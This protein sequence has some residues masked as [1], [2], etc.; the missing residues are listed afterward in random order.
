MYVNELGRDRFA[1][2]EGGGQLGQFAPGPGLSG[3]RSPLSISGMPLRF[4]QQL[5][6]G[7]G[8][9]L[10]LGLRRAWSEFFKRDP[11]LQVCFFYTHRP[12]EGT[13]FWG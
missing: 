10:V 6:H 13:W 2:K 5:S 1:A 11:S 7:S 12:I 9:N 3:A 4:K 8:R